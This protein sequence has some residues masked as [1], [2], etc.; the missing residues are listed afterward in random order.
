MVLVGILRQHI[1]RLIASEPKAPNMEE[2]KQSTALKQG[3]VLRVSHYVMNSDSFNYRRDILLEDYREGKFLLE[4]D[5]NT[6]ALANPLADPSGLDAMTNMMKG[7]LMNFVPQTIIMGWINLFFSGFVLIKLPFPLPGRF[8]SIL[9][10]GVMTPDLD[11]QWVSSISWYF[12]NLFGLR[13]VYTLLLGNE[14][15]PIDMGIDPSKMTATQ[16]F[17]KP[18]YKKLFESESGNLSLVQHVWILDDVESRVLHAE[19]IHA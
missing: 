17:G 11:V 3:E 8:K 16:P 14:G 2:L 15:S 6:E 13:G 4:K 18:D 7:N 5:K 10:S 12:L 19:M 9:Q 1:T